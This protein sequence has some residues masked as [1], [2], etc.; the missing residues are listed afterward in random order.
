[1]L[2]LAIIDPGL[3]NY[4]ADERLM[5]FYRDLIEGVEDLPGVRTA[6]FSTAVPLVDWSNSS[7]TFADERNYEVTESGVSAWLASRD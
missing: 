5:E 3:A 1:M 4:E 2:F 7:I 6:A